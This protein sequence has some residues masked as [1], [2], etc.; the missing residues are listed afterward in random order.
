ML[1]GGSKMDVNHRPSNIHRPDVNEA[2]MAE[3]RTT[4][5][6]RIASCE[7]QCGAPVSWQILFVY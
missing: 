4:V 3:L 1:F 5:F 2:A 7:F 6:G